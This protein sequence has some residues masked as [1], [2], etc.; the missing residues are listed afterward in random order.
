MT[1]VEAGRR[2]G[3]ARGKGIRAGTI[4]LSGAAVPI[5]TKCPR[6]HKVQPSARAAWRHCRNKKRGR[7]A[8]TAPKKR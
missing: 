8:K 6:C 2:G 4:P 7:P 5:P 1:V 3:I